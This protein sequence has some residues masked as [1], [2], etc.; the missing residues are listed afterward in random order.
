[1]ST[2]DDGS[3]T[4][5]MYSVPLC[6]FKKAQTVDFQLRIFEHTHTP[7]PHLWWKYFKALRGR[8]ASQSLCKSTENKEQGDTHV[9]RAACLPVAE[10][11]KSDTFW[12]TVSQKQSR[13]QLMKD[14]ASYV[15]E[16]ELQVQSPREALKSFKQGT[17]Q[18]HL[19]Y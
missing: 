4:M 11:L 5:G 3:P 1:M 8:E 14:S 18:P 16:C 9:G 10:S 7:Y 6:T 17:A 13:C 15:K 19:D 2:A 12:G